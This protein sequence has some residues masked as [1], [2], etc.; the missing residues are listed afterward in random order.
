MRRFERYHGVAPATSIENKWDREESRRGDFELNAVVNHPDNPDDVYAIANNK[1]I[2]EMRWYDELWAN[3]MY[4]LIPD[5]CII[6]KNNAWDRNF[7]MQDRVDFFDY[8]AKFE[9]RWKRY[10]YEECEEDLDRE[11]EIGGDSEMPSAS[12]TALDEQVAFLAPEYLEKTGVKAMAHEMI[13]DILTGFLCKE[14]GL[15]RFVRFNHLAP[16][17]FDAVTFKSSKVYTVTYINGELVFGR[18]NTIDQSWNWIPFKYNLGRRRV[19]ARL[20]TDGQILILTFHPYCFFEYYYQKPFVFRIDESFS[21]LELIS[22]NRHLRVRAG[23]TEQQ[24][25]LARIQFPELINQFYVT[26]GTD[27]RKP[28]DKCDFQIALTDFD[29]LGGL[30][31][32]SHWPDENYLDKPVTFGGV[33]GCT[34]G[35]GDRFYMHGIKDDFLGGDAVIEAVV[36]DHTTDPVGELITEH[37]PSA[38][39]ITDGERV[40][41]VGGGGPWVHGNV[42][43]LFHD[44]PR[45][46][47]IS[48]PP[49]PEAEVYSPSERTTRLYSNEGKLLRTKVTRSYADE[50]PAE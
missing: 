24:L 26:Y 11:F 34:T 9:P 30:L 12:L 6:S 21:R 45:K 46:E 42:D 47:Y 8:L 2:N 23:Y 3:K 39:V 36:E 33:E 18:F 44:L 48:I 20:F 4:K 38:P 29:T 50:D 32:G 28:I 40:F 16:I 43:D 17:K 25:E 37:R 27:A 31:L 14:Y 1:L 35:D 22:K 15:F 13:D 10:T 49:R 41:I 7:D 19:I 5:R